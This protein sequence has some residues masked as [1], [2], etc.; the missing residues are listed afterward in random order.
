MVAAEVSNSSS[1]SSTRYFMMVEG[2][3]RTESERDEYPRIKARARPKMDGELFW[4]PRAA[5][6]TIN[7]D[8]GNRSEA[9][10]FGP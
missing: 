8:K 7:Y 3:K 10:R 5:R 1:I 4:S 6:G 2:A 9:V